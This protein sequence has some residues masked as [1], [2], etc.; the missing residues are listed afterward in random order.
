MVAENIDT[1]LRDVPESLTARITE[2]DV[3]YIISPYTLRVRITQEP[4]SVR[5]EPEMAR[6][7]TEAAGIRRIVRAQMPGHPR[8]G[9]AHKA[10]SR[11]VLLRRAEIPLSAKQRRMDQKPQLSP[12][13]ERPE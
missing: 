5:T 1:P 3:L 11:E 4:D 10:G 9:P 2:L 8:L 6:R 12:A 7:R 13:E